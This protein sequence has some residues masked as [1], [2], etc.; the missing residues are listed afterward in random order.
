MASIFRRRISEYASQRDIR[1]GSAIQPRTLRCLRQKQKVTFMS[2]NKRLPPH[3]RDLLAKA[4]YVF[5]NR[6]NPFVI[7]WED[8]THVDRV[9]ESYKT[10]INM[11]ET[12]FI[13][14]DNFVNNGNK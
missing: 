5:D 13:E 3:I 2:Q 6:K 4:L 11:L 9:Q 7:R 8:L 1:R 12:A 10:T 14:F